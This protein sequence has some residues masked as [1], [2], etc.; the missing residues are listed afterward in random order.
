MQKYLIDMLACPVCHSELDWSIIQQTNARVEEAEARCTS[1]S[2]SYPIREGIGIFLID[3]LQ[4]KDP[5]EQVD[6]GLM[7]YLRSHPELYEQ[8]MTAP[9]ESLSPADQFFRGMLLEELGK[10][11]EAREAHNTAMR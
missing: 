3:E 2:R 5:W 4:R 11:P 9:L 7:K 1:C 8:L 10:F 6:S